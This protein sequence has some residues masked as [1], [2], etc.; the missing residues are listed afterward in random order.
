M[1]A[2]SYGLLIAN[3]YILKCL[4]FIMIFLT[5]KDA[6]LKNQFCRANSNLNKYLY[7]NNSSSDIMTLNDKSIHI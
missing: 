3:L 6:S 7:M 4:T 5:L 1:N 2:V